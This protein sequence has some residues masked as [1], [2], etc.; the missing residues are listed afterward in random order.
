[1]DE[2]AIHP[3][4]GVLNHMK[5]VKFLRDYSAPEIDKRLRTYYKF[6]FVREPI[7]RLVSAFLNKFR[8]IPDFQRRHGVEIIRKYRKNPPQFTQGDDVTFEEFVRSLLDKLPE[9]FNEHWMPIEHLCHPC[10]V[11]YDFIGAY[12]NLEAEANHVIRHV[13]ASRRVAFPAPQSYYKPAGSKKVQ[14]LYNTLT[15]VQKQRLLQ[16]F[17]FDFEAF[18]YE[19]PKS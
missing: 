4:D 18:N 1:M 14:L 5:D 3:N 2:K 15:P 7:S 16:V 12:E 9:K 17:S 10:V 6:T 19:I 13:N 11:K 8:E